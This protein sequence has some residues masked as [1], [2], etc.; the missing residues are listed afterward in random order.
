MR[1]LPGSTQ[2]RPDLPPTKQGHAEWLLSGAVHPPG[3]PGD[4]T[5]TDLTLTP[6][7]G[8]YVLNGRRSVN[9]A[10]TVADQFMLDAV[11]TTTGDVLVMGIGSGQRG[12]TGT[13]TP[14]RLGLR[15]PGPSPSTT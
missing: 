5:P 11:S 3:L 10:V 2:P 12:V 14:D 15:T 9:A 1:G 7:N 13:P 4:S 6:T 8:T